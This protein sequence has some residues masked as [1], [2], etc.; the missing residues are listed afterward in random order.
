[1]KYS[2]V[3]HIIINIIIPIPAINVSGVDEPERSGTPF[4]YLL[5]S[6]N[7][8]SGAFVKL[9]GTLSTY[10]SSVL[11]KSVRRDQWRQAAS[12]S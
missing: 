9:S 1:M 5:F 2:V 10:R 12:F 3:C 8:D 11:W 6:R 4:G 7:E